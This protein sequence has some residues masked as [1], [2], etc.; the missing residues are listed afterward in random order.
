MCVVC[1]VRGRGYTPTGDTECEFQIVNSLRDFTDI[2]LRRALESGELLMLPEIQEFQYATLWHPAQ[3]IEFDLS[4]YEREYKFTWI[5]GIIWTDG[6]PRDQVFYRSIT[7]LRF[8]GRAGGGYHGEKSE[9]GRKERSF[10]RLCTLIVPLIGLR[11]A[12]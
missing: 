9:D 1:K 6:E 12:A 10:D 3:F 4:R 5:P 8:W 7:H 11:G 2:H